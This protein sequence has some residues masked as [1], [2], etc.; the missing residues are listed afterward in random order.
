M[1]LRVLGGLDFYSS[2]DA[3]AENATRQIRQILG[4]LALAGAKGLSRAELCALFWPDRAPSQ[5]RNSLRQGLAAIRKLLAGTAEGARITLQSDLETVRLLSDYRAID[6]HTFELGCT[7]T[8]P[9]GLIDAADAY[10][11]EVFA[12]IQSTAEI[13]EWLGPFRRHLH[14]RALELAERLSKSNEAA[15]LDA[16]ERLA[17]RLLS[18]A[19]AAE[20][21]HRSIMRV[22][23]RRGRQNAALRQFEICKTAL[24]NELQ[25]SPDQ[26]TTQL[27]AAIRGSITSSASDIDTRSPAASAPSRPSVAVM[28]FEN[29]GDPSDEYFAD[30]VVDEITSALSRI[31]DFVVIARQSAFTYKG[32]FVDVQ[33]I[34][35]ELG[36][37][38]VI[39]GTVR[40]GNDR[41]RISVQLVD[42][43]SRAQLWS[44]R[45]EGAATDVFEFQD[46]IAAQVAGAMHPAVRRAE[47][48]AAIRKPRS[49]LGAYDLVM[50][51]YPYLWGQNAEAINAAIPLLEEAQRIDPAY[52]RALALLAWCHALKSTYLWSSNPEQEADEAMDLARRAIGLVDEDPTAMTAVGA[53]MS[54]CG[55]TEG[56]AGLIERALTLDPNNAWA[57]TRLGWNAVYGGQSATALAHFEKAMSLSPV[58]PFAFNT[59]MGRGAALVRMGRLKEGISIARDVV[60]KHPEVTWAFRQL[61]AWSAMNGD[62]ETAHWAGER[63]LASQP[64]FTI[65]RYLRIPTFQHI[66]RYRDEMAEGLRKAG[67]PES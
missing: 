57:W 47:I 40:R 36:V 59:N 11:G 12:G 33:Q 28:A 32:R 66:A 4:C 60:H 17:G 9:S 67:L 46:R 29:L 7:A 49:S 26:E 22:H 43:A 35:R 24:A 16:A 18:V 64:D 44:D 50:R 5:A 61:A 58:D 45:F 2:A 55:D 1:R 14:Q 53:A 27:L 37:T 56:A 15:A 19:P 23:L 51:A 63:L 3:A 42:T 10:Q 30:G 31:R 54:L 62:V 41:L 52:G 6:V 13:E 34:G 38:Y 20:E 48:E 39:E 8:D 21:A 25:T 65:Q